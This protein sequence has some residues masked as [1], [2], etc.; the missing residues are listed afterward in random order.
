MQE[1]PVILSQQECI[2]PQVSQQSVIEYELF[3]TEVALI[4]SL[5]QSGT[6][7]HYRIDR[8]HFF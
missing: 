3:T 2:G 6:N 1:K 5:G 7:T 4:H 8:T